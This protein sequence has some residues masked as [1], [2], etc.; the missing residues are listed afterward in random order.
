MMAWWSRKKELRKQACIAELMR[1]LPAG[2]P[3]SKDVDT[4]LLSGVSYPL[5]AREV[6][7]HIVYI[8]EIIQRTMNFIHDEDKKA[9]GRLTFA[10]LNDAMSTLD[11]LFRTRAQLL[12]LVSFSSRMVEK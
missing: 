2:N 3:D 7:S 1:L 8:E 6:L 10:T 12:S 11:N 5:L 9:K 4:V